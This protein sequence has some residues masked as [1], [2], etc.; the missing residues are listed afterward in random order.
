M[1][2]KIVEVSDEEAKEY[3]EKNPSRGGVLFEQIKPRVKSYLKRKQEQ[4]SRSSFL[5][6]LRAS[7][8]VQIFLQPMKFDV[9]SA[10]SILE[11]L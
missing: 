4:D 9:S 11:A 10:E 1:T 7:A 3:F 2:D 6:S 5:A 8:G